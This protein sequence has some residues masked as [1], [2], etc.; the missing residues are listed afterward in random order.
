MPERGATIDLTTSELPS[1][2]RT[3]YRTLSRLTRLAPADDWCVIGGIMTELNLAARHTGPVPLLT[4]DADIVADVFRHPWS[5]RTLGHALMSLGYF[6]VPAG[7][8]LDIASRFHEA[9][10]STHIDLLAPEYSDRRRDLTTVGKR[11]AL[12]ARGADFALETARLVDVRLPDLHS[13][14]IRVPTLAGAIYTKATS[15]RRVAL[16]AEKHLRDSVRLLKVA[17]PEDFSGCPR[18]LAKRL[19]W[20]DQALASGEADEYA[21]PRERVKIREVIEAALSQPGWN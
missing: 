15:Y 5:L 3:L 10:S 8:S 12:T 18:A 14:N 17:A 21:S 4:Q 2:Q 6:P 1:V 19:S 20:L 11:R 7:T 9:A 13:V 16:R